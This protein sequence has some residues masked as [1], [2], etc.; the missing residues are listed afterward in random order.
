M[1]VG[2]AL[3]PLS[4]PALDSRAVARALGWVTLVLAGLYVMPAAHTD[5]P[6][7]LQ[8][9]GAWAVVLRALPCLVV[10]AMIALGA[11]LA[12]LAFDRGGSRR[13]VLL[14]GAGSIAANLL[15]LLHCPMTAPVHMLVGHLG[16]LVLVV[17]AALVAQSIDRSSG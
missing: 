6:A 13:A 1:S 16:V 10:G 12:L 3:R 8:Q 15:L 7:S 11:V 2:L 17:A 4:R 14:A 9:P 5:H